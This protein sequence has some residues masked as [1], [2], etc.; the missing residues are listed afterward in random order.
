MDHR[1]S[2]ALLPDV[3]PKEWQDHIDIVE[4]SYEYFFAYAAQGIDRNSGISGELREY[5]SR[6]REALGALEEGLGEMVEGL[7]SGSAFGPMNEVMKRDARDAK[8]MVS[9]VMAQTGVS[10]ALM[11]NFNI[12]TRWRALLTD[13]FVIDEA[14]KSTLGEA[15]PYPQEEKELN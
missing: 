1:Q 6:T 8:A 5:L 9:L 14:L 7:D 3:T 15:Y 2:R 4:E 11:D 13:L 10:S 12:S